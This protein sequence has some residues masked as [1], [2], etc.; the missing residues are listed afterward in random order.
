MQ[1]RD[2]QR[3]VPAFVEG[4]MMTYL[5]SYI[6]EC[7]IWWNSIWAP[8]VS[9][10]LNEEIRKGLSLSSLASAS[11]NLSWPL[12]Q[13][14]YPGMNGRRSYLWESTGV[15]EQ[16]VPDVANLR[17]DQLKQLNTADVPLEFWVR[18]AHA[19]FRLVRRDPDDSVNTGL[20]H[21]LIQKFKS[22]HFLRGE[23]FSD[24][25]GAPNAKKKLE[26]VNTY[27]RVSEGAVFTTSAVLSLCFVAL[28][29]VRRVW[30]DSTSDALTL[31]EE[32]KIMLYVGHAIDKWNKGDREDPV[33]LGVRPNSDL[34]GIAAVARRERSEAA[35]MLQQ[36]SRNATSLE[37]R[38][39]PERS[40]TIQKTITAEDW[41]DCN[42]HWLEKVLEKVAPEELADNI[43]KHITEATAPLVSEMYREKIL[44]ACYELELSNHII[45][46]QQPAE[47][48]ITVQFLSK[49]PYLTPGPMM[50]V[51]RELE[52]LALSD[53]DRGL[54][55]KLKGLSDKIADFQDFTN[56]QDKQYLT[57]QRECARIMYDLMSQF[58]TVDL[59]KIDRAI[60]ET[61]TSNQG[62]VWSWFHGA[63]RDKGKGLSNREW[64][65]EYRSMDTEW[66]DTYAM[67]N[68]A[69]RA[70]TPSDALLE[71]F[72][73]LV[74]KHGSSKLIREINENLPFW[75]E[76]YHQQH[77]T[78]APGTGNEPDEIIEINQ[79]R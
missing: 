31:M 57:E 23:N 68:A 4:L 60:Q 17:A 61:N 65:A 25:S 32:N 50:E 46:L 39:Q 22:T 18:L 66:V 59:G 77:R 44:L 43:R 36:P 51:A 41:H 11:L 27:N 78:K 2:L 14:T 33:Y 12:V 35:F 56:H 71:F 48:Q 3:W 74:Y 67:M 21:K 9:I 52:A 34:A 63:T 54:A 10:D 16:K 30:N 20:V 26:M 19:C 45:W 15:P 53:I 8:P 5:G 69:I 7:I 58:R 40:T 6:R 42:R 49:E 13:G 73:K 28:R 37:P 62:K 47:E 79:R 24:W 75:D 38:Q 1:D 76:Q 55:L 72:S 64:L 29:L 70:V